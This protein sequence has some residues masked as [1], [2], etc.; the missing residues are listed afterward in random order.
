MSP[1]W[2]LLFL[3]PADDCISELFFCET[4]NDPVCK[5]RSSSLEGDGSASQKSWLIDGHIYS[6]IERHM[7]CCV[8]ATPP[9]EKRK[10]KLFNFFQRLV[11]INNEKINKKSNNLFFCCWDIALLLKLFKHNFTVSLE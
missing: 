1:K 10:S 7:N 3:R 4:I 8:M 6:Q 9:P 5:K 2:F 11:D